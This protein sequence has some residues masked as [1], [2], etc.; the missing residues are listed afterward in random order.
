MEHTG[1][2]LEEGTRIAKLI[3]VQKTGNNNRGNIIWECLCDCGNFTELD[4]LQLKRL[5]VPSCGC[6]KPVKGKDLTGEQFGRLTVVSRDKESDG[7]TYKWNCICECG[8][9]LKVK[10]GALTSK[11]TQSC[12]CMRADSLRLFNETQ[13]THK[14]SSTRA[15]GIYLKMLSRCFDPG[16][17]DYKDYGA[18]GIGVSERW[19]AEFPQGLVNFFEDMGEPP[20]G[21]SID[22][23]DVNGDYCLENCKW[24]TAQ[25]QAFNQRRPANNRTGKT[26]VK[27][28]PDG[29]Y[30]AS[31][32][33]DGKRKHLY[34]GH[35]LE[36]AIEIRKQAE[37]EVYGF[38]KD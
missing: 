11:N 22:R 17:I 32:M 12:G 35:D 28:H 33:I 1:I 23:R 30:M 25:I 21:M 27:H 37:L 5:Q 20:A 18:R 3:L 16:N 19:N 36:K 9:Q 10:R 8:T 7:K 2:I 38:I 26:G 24:E 6:A 4:S 31:I 29:G 13:G 14:L 15:Y 34:Y